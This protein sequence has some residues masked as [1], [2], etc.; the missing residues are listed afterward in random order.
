M[1]V[2]GNISRMPAGGA[3]GRQPAVGP[4]VPTVR[5]GN[6]GSRDDR[7]STSEKHDKVVQSGHVV[8]AKVKTKAKVEEPREQPE[9]VT[10]DPIFDRRVGSSRSGVYVDLV[11]RN[12]NF[13]A[14]RLFGTSGN[15]DEQGTS[16]VEGTVSAG[17]AAR[18][19]RA[20]G[21]ETDLRSSTVL[22]S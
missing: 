4:I 1:D 18:A 17:D 20:A 13:R 8:A 22:T 15:R 11:Y 16:A 19:Y 2:V 21:T 9:P 7:Q 12:T 6:D 5:G 10:I 3:L 14:V